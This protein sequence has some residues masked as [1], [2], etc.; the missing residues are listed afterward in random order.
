MAQFDVSHPVVSKRGKITKITN[1]EHNNN[2]VIENIIDTDL[3]LVNSIDLDETNKLLYF[4]DSTRQVIEV[5]DLRTKIRKVLI[6][7]DVINPQSLVVSPKKKLLFWVDYGDGINNVG[8]RIWKAQSNGLNPE[9]LVSQ[10]NIIQPSHLSLNSNREMLVWLEKLQS[11][12]YEI[13]FDGSN[14]NTV[15]TGLKEAVA[16]NSMAWV[17]RNLRFGFAGKDKHISVSYEYDVS[18]DSAGFRNSNRNFG[19]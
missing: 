9:I 18:D 10:P 8:P 3:G 12:V 17:G 5:F 6:T 14:K 13:K 4:T 11:R 2:P 1:W 7:E 19:Y 15:N 16:L